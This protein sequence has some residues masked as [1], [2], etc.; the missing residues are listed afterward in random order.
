MNAAPL[1]LLLGG[2]GETAPLAEAIAAAG[3]GVLVSTATDE[4]LDVG[5]HPS[6]ERRAGRLGRE[7]LGQL[8]RE[9][10]V[11]A[12]VDAAH[13]YAL[14]LHANAFAAAADTDLAYIRYERP[15]GVWHGE[16]VTLAADHDVAA[17]IAF[18]F[19]RPVLLTT[20]SRNLLPYVQWSGRTNLPLF[21]RV[22]PGE[23]VDVCRSAGIP[24][25]RIIGLRGPFSFE[26]NVQHLRESYAGVL[27]TKDSGQAGGVPE[28]VAAARA[29]GCRI[30]V[31]QRTSPVAAAC[32]EQ[33]GG[34]A[35]TLRRIIASIQYPGPSR[36]TTPAGK[37]FDAG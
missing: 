11:V 23:S 4:I 15:P 25:Q 24:P 18:S 26:Q 5:K 29:L 13:P 10:Q 16:D 1:V 2:T 34:V 33:Q 21:A 14:E 28:K 19:S 35:E 30:V 27:V 6:I 12:I 31:V 37:A 22:L 32:S 17:K 3:F 8:L 36:S 20:G 9:R 7:A